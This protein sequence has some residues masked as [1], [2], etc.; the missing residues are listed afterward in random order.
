MGIINW[1]VKVSM[2]SIEIANEVHWKVG[3]VE[4]SVNVC[5]RYASVGS[6]IRGG[7]E[8]RLGVGENFN[9]EKAR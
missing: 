6:G 3:V 8:E 9:S 1:V 2:I 4:E 5:V 7:Y